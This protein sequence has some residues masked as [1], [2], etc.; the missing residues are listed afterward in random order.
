MLAVVYCGEVINPN[1][2]TNPKCPSALCNQAITVKV[3]P[4]IEK[5]SQIWSLKML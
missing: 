1:I 3:S 2:E 4:I 5:N